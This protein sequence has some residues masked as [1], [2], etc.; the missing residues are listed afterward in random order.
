MKFLPHDLRQVKYKILWLDS[1]NIYFSLFG[2]EHSKTSSFECFL[3]EKWP[4]AFRGQTLTMCHCALL[5]GQN[6][7][8][9]LVE[10]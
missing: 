10:D 4:W 5:H 3:T 2:G 6:L 7:S 9:G 8:M 1:K